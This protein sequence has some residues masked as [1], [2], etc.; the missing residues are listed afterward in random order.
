MKE[1]QSIRCSRCGDTMI[2]RD[3]DVCD[4][5]IGEIE[6]REYEMQMEREYDRYMERMYD[7]L[8]REE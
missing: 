8:Q 7:T 2:Y 6:D 3:E 1:G 5:C 4:R